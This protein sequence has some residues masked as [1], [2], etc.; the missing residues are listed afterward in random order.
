MVQNQNKQDRGNAQSSVKSATSQLPKQISQSTVIDQE[1]AKDMKPSQAF[2]PGEIKTTADLDLSIN[3]VLDQILT[4]D[5]L[6]VSIIY[7]FEAK[8]RGD[9]DG[10]NENIET[11]M[12][13][14]RKYKYAPNDQG[15]E[16]KRADFMV[17]FRT[18]VEKMTG[19]ILKTDERLVEV[20]AGEFILNAEK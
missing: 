1:E 11:L 14:V 16:Q 12:A 8:A 4:L 19:N 13:I 15:L 3:F 10:L 9:K 6:M 17:E 2:R 5:Q 20:Y 7:H 18:A